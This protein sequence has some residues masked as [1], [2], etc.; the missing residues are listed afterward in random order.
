[1]G[2]VME[3]APP[4]GQ[5]SSLLLNNTNLTVSLVAFQPNEAKDEEDRGAKDLPEEEVQ[6]RIQ[7]YNSKVS[8]IGMNLVRFQFLQ[9]QFRMFMMPSRILSNELDI[10]LE[11]H[12]FRTNKLE[13]N[14]AISNN[15]SG[16]KPAVYQCVYC[17]LY[18]SSKRVGL[19]KCSFTL[20]SLSFSLWVLGVRWNLLRLHQGPPEAQST[21]HRPHCRGDGLRWNGHTQSSTIRMPGNGRLCTE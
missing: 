19:L 3:A 9:L 5:N 4:A 6:T 18:C 1:M 7:E 13:H 14:V 11:L 12:V 21:S 16:N 2:L 8:E 10:Y 20:F 17:V 15:K